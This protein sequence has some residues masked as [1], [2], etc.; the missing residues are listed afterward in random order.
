MI[1]YNTEEVN[2]LLNT[3]SASY[4]KL[5][6]TMATGWDVV[7]NTL[8][9]E[10]IGPDELAYETELANRMCTLYYACRESVE[11]M[12]TNVRSIGQAWQDFQNSNVIAGGVATVAAVNF[13]LDMAA[14]PDYAIESVVKAAERTFTA[15]MRMGVTNGESSATTINTE[16][17]NYVNTIGETVKAM[18]DTTSSANAF[19]GSQA[20][21]ID[22][23]L[24]K[25]AD[26][27]SKVT[28]Q[29]SDLQTTLT[30]LVKNYNDQ[31]AA[32]SQQVSGLDTSVMMS[33]DTSST[34]AQ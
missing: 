5:G 6:E 27:F 4:Q 29:V 31:M 21:T 34:S 3:L 24:K 28:T 30:Q 17:T 13:A 18:Y 7:S 23:Y 8:G 26:A 19:L 2:T 25:M 22:E 10:W 14:L 16:V 1:G 12:I 9:A 32:L 20:E 11:G 15:N 33:A